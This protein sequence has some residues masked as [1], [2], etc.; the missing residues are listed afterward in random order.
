VDKANE[1]PGGE[2]EN[3]LTNSERS[4]RSFVVNQLRTG[5]PALWNELVWVLE[6]GWD[7]KIHQR[8]QD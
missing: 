4:K 5:S 3:E 7:W 6:C 8:K 2:E 1:G